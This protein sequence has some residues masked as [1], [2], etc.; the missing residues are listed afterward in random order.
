[1]MRS[2]TMVSIVFLGLMLET[3]LGCGK[4]S[5][6]VPTVEVAGKVTLDGR[7]LDG[8]EVRFVTEKHAG[9]AL[10]EVDG[11]FKLNNGAQAGPNKITVSKIDQSKLP[12]NLRGLSMA[13]LESVA[14]AQGMKALPGQVVPAKYS[15]PV[16]TTL[17]LD[18][19]AEGTKSADFGLT[20]K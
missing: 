15:D 16:N 2:R 8:A 19:P 4:T 9:F 11:S 17:S 3:L 7:P 13:D 14:Q 10:T 1:M 18:V 5:Q 6:G 12:P 20:S